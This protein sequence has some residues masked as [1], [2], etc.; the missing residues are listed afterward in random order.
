MTKR[1]LNYRGVAAAKREKRNLC[2]IAFA[3][4]VTVAPF[5]GYFAF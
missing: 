5:V 2:F 4:M 3:L 1:N